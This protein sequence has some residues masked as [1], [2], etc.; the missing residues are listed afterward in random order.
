MWDGL[1]QSDFL[2]SKRK[3]KLFFSPSFQGKCKV[4]NKAGL[5]DSEKGRGGVGE[6][7]SGNDLDDSGDQNQLYYEVRGDQELLQTQNWMCHFVSWP[8]TYAE[9]KIFNQREAIN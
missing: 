2:N 1:L 9:F 5:I 7:E 4:E 8:L 6:G 3:K